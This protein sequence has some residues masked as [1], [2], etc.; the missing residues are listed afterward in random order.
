[1]HQ[2]RQYNEAASPRSDSLA[3]VQWLAEFCRFVHACRECQQEIVPHWQLCTHCEIRL[4]ISCPRCAGALP[5]A[6]AYACPCCG[7]AMPPVE[8][9]VKGLQAQENDRGKVAW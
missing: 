3:Q 8:A 4:A 6:G 2:G 1:M 5:P 7:Y 9:W